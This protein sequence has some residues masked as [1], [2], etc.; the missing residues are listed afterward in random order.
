MIK[1][2]KNEFLK[3]QIYS[4]LD[5]YETRCNVTKE[6]IEEIEQLQQKNKT[7]KENAENNDKVVDKVNWENMLLKKENK[8]L[9]DELKSKP[10][11]QITLQDDKGNKFMVIQTE[12]IDMQVELNKTIEKLFNNWNKLKEYIRKNIIYDDVG[13]KILDPSPLEDYIQELE[14]SD[15]NE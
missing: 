11:V 2:D 7:L 3:P 1:F 12:R 10:D 13:M 14:G 8:Q 15:S 6:I 4:T 5:E 9:K